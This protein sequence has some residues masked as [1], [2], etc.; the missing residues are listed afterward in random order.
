[1]LP[2]FIAV[3][4]FNG[5]GIEDLAVVNYSAN[6]GTVLLGKGDG[7]FNIKSTFGISSSSFAVGDFNGDGLPDLATGTNVLLGKGDGTFTPEP[8]PVVGATPV[9]G[10]FN[11]DGFTD[12]AMTV[13]NTGSG[14]NPGG[15]INI[16]LG[17]GDGAFNVQVA[18]SPALNPYWLVTG[19][20]NGDG[21]LDI[22]ALDVTSLTQIPLPVIRVLLNQLTQ[23][24]T[25]SVSS[26]SVTAGTSG[27]SWLSG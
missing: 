13:A 25:A 4:D 27:D 21:V 12:L 20:F 24:A 10:D 3:A 9:V 11:G 7:T 5:D 8:L 17:G 26:V 19:D 2:M 22:A 15:T 6:T 16:L 23:T 1:M 18:P 14:S